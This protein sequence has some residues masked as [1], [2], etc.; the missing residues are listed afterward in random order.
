MGRTFG[1]ML[2]VAVI[3]SAMQPMLVGEALAY[4]DPGT[5]GLLSQILYV[6][7]YGVLAAF[8]Y[9]FRYIKQCVANIKQIV[10]KLLGR[11]SVLL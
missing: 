8:L 1:G 6:I 9:F 7:F 2:M 5:T 10:L 3:A 4:I 11:V